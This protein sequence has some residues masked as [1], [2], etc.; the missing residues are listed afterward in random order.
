MWGRMTAKSTALNA[1]TGMVGYD[2]ELHNTVVWS[3][4]TGDMVMFSSPA[5]ADGNL[6]V[7]AYNGKIY[8]LNAK[9]GSYL[10]SYQ[11]GYAVVSSPAVDNGVVYVGSEDNSIYA[12]NASNGELALEVHNWRPDCPILASSTRTAQST[13]AQT[14]ATSTH[15]TPQWQLTLEIRHRRHSGFFTCNP[16]RRSLCWL[17][18]PQ[19]LRPKCS[20]RR[21]ALEL[22]HGW[23]CF[24]YHQP[25]PMDWSMWVLTTATFTH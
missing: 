17:I 20:G 6:Y 18:R 3:Y 23:R 12:L 13:L 25:L 19:H 16:R 15:S 8:C 7:G 4:D 2:W 1:S 24:V 14:T 21:V 22:H 9:T 5:V 10:W 11:T